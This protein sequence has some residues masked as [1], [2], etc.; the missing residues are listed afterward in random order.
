MHELVREH[1]R[2]KT[3]YGPVGCETCGRGEGYKGRT[4]VHELLEMTP[5]LRELA[6]QAVHSAVM[7]KAAVKE[8]MIT[9][10]QDATVKVLDGQTTFEEVLKIT[11]RKDLK[12]G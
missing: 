1:L 10:Q 7:R 5:A 3:I 4:G 6:F 11:H 9:L 8:G 12:L 2:G